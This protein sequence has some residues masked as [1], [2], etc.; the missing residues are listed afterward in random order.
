MAR[1]TGGTV[2]GAVVPYDRLEVQA[3]QA[4]RGLMVAEDQ[5]QFAAQNFHVIDKGQNV[6]FS[7]SVP[8]TVSLVP[9][10]TP[11]RKGFWGPHI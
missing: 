6:S 8:W 5:Q 3:A 9:Q 7:I 4:G 2:L 10:A 11:R 1:A